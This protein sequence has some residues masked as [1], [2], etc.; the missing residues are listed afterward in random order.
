MDAM[1]ILISLIGAGVLIALGLFSLRLWLQRAFR[2]RDRRWVNDP[3]SLAI[4]AERVRVPTCRGRTL[5]AAWYLSHPGAPVV[6]MVHGWGANGSHLLFMVPRLLSEGLNVAVFDAR[7]HGQSDDDTFASL[8]RF[9]EDA[10]AVMAG[11]R[12]RGHGDFILLGH[13]VGAGAV[14]LT[15]SR[16]PGIRAVISL[17]AFSHPE[18]MMNGWLQERG[19]PRRPLGLIINRSV[20]WL[21]GHRFDDIAPR[22]TV[23]KIKA[24]LLLVH[25]CQD[26]VVP[27]WHARRLAQENPQA[28][29]LKLPD[30]QHN[31]PE[32][33]ARHVAP[34][35][36]WLRPHLRHQAPVA[37]SEQ[38]RVTGTG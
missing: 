20:E 1:T 9:A 21:I 13:S 30:V 2:I 14:L 4:P 8:P 3:E 5:S 10:E 37:P 33:F 25:G 17:S 22:T 38:E 36:D 27:P 6:V 16:N 32:G 35:L 31:D 28:T 29:L 7:C 24:P 23:A 15:A 11:L 12:A 18:P 34:I 26:T 19:I